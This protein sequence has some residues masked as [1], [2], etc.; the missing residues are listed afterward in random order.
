MKEDFFL[1]SRAAVASIPWMVWGKILNFVIYFF[2]S[3]SIARR[4]SAEEFGAWSLFANIAE[5]MMVCCQ[6]GLHQ[7]LLRYVPEFGQKGYFGTIR[8]FASHALSLELAVLFIGAIIL[9]L[10][11]P[12]LGTLFHVNLHGEWLF[13]ALFACGFLLKDFFSALATALYYS[14]FLTVASC[15]QGLLLLGMLWMG[16]LH[17]RKVLEAQSL[18]LI[19]FALLSWIYLQ[20]K[21]PYG[22]GE[23]VPNGRIAK[24]SL[25][26]CFNG[27]L[28]KFSSQYSEIFFL[29]FYTTIETVGY[30]GL[31]FSQSFLLMTLLP[32]SLH[33]LFTSAVA[34]AT[35][36]NGEVLPRII[37]SLFSILIVMLVPVASFAFFFAEPGFILLFGKKMA[38]AGVLAGYLCMLHLLGLF[39][40]PLSL[41][42]IAKEK[43][44]QTLPLQV[45]YVAA[46]ILA[47]WLLIPRFGVW[48]ALGAIFV[49]FALMLPYRI[50]VVRSIIGGIF[51][52][53]WFFCRVCGLTLFIAFLFHY[54]VAMTSITRLVVMSLL[55]FGVAYS[56]LF[57]LSTKK[58]KEDILALGVLPWQRK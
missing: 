50:R 45:S 26:S 56:L 23:E 4:L 57:V 25:P 52:P 27:I 20:H 33:T 6:L 32:L 37:K 11:S 28:N 51:F 55:Y 58:D 18:S 2:I 1:F 15:F 31:G 19:A 42:I 35:T 8:L 14:R 12:F 9:G 36:K 46:N 34:E 10:S 41:G 39:S 47:D 3:V 21:I 53:G 38:F 7:A 40:Y 24:F 48:G 49:T 13:V 29:G 30:Y 22:G 43:I 17:V 54:F 5:I 44:A 16:Q